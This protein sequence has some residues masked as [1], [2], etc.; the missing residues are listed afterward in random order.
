MKITKQNETFNLSDTTDVFE[1]NGNAS[2][3]VNGTLNLHI[4]V[5]KVGGENV[6]D[7]YYNRYAESSNVNFGLNCSEENRDALTAYADTVIDTVLEHFN[8]IN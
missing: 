6:G 4:N 3:E 7:C 1:M 8:L 5:N 2:Y